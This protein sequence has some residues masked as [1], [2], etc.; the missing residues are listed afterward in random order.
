[1]DERM[2]SS[3]IQISFDEAVRAFLVP[4]DV[5]VQRGRLYLFKREYRP[6][7]P[8]SS[9]LTRELAHRNGLVLRGYVLDFAPR[10]MW[11]EWNGKLHE[12]EAVV[13]GNDPVKFASLQEIE[14]IANDRA[15]ASGDTQA[16]VP[17]E[18]LAAQDKFF[19]ETGIEMSAGRTVRGGKK[20]PNKDAEDE[21]RRIRQK[22][23]S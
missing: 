5:K 15:R 11:V 6:E 4:V 20:R 1:M 23:S 17:I 9:E 8:R 19:K 14:N 21:M 22:E 10:F 2:R 13:E 18:T 16:A 7:S 12:V 3:F